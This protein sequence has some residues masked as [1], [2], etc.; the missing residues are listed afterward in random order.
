MLLPNSGHGIFTQFHP[1]SPPFTHFVFISTT[2]THFEVDFS[3]P[4]GRQEGRGYAAILTHI[5]L[6]LSL[7]IKQ[8]F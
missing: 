3:P 2:S 1:V 4:W 5:L 6:V 8:G 7:I